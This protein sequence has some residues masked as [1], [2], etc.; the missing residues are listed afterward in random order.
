[1]NKTELVAAVAAKADIKKADAE[2]AVNAAIDVIIESI[3]NGEKV[4][5]V[6]FGTFEQRERGARTGCNPKT[7][8]KIEIAACK[9]PAFRLVR[10]SRTLLISNFV[11][12][13]EQALGLLTV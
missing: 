8:E 12:F 2:K 13:S 4:Q 1:M 11:L 7:N 10:L 9:V 3:T 6:G 5:L